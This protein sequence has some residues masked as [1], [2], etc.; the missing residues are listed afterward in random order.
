MEPLAVDVTDSDVVEVTM[1][2]VLLRST[3]SGDESSDEREDISFDAVQSPP[4]SERRR[5]G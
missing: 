4:S 1:G 2:A 5:V 3:S